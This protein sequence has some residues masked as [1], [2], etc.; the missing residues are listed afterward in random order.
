MVKTQGRCGVSL[1]FTSFSEDTVRRTAY[2]CSCNLVVQWSRDGMEGVIVRPMEVDISCFS[3][4]FFRKLVR[5]FF[6]L[7]YSVYFLYTK[8]VMTSV[9]VIQKC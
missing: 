7:H 5:I 1:S 8:K 4:T 2:Q 9:H 3:S 6:I